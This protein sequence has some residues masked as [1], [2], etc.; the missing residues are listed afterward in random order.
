MDGNEFLGSLEIQEQQLC[1]PDVG[2]AGAA[3]A[4]EERWDFKILRLVALYLQRDVIYLKASPI[5]GNFEQLTGSV[6]SHKIPP[7]FIGAVKIDHEKDGKLRFY[8]LFFENSNKFSKF[9]SLDIITND[10]RDLDQKELFEQ[11]KRRLSLKQGEKPVLEV[12]SYMSKIIPEALRKRPIF[13]KEAMGLLT[14]LHTTRD[15]HVGSP[16]L[17]VILDSQ[18]AYFLFSKGISEAVHKVHR[19]SITLHERYPNTLLYAVPSA[20]NIADFLS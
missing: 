3:V 14:N 19:W 13:E 1:H 17:L 2:N 10:Y 15:M 16:P 12:I 4:L 7:F 20:A 8:S 11:V 18:T 5:G 6:K 9:S